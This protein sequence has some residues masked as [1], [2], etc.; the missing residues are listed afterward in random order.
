MH[1]EAAGL[2]CV[3]EGALDHQIDD[4][5]PVREETAPVG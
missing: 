2:V 5:L 4:A 3:I 1:F